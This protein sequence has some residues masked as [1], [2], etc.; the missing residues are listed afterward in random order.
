MT[1]FTPHEI[2]FALGRLIESWAQPLPTRIDDAP[3][4]ELASAIAGYLYLVGSING[5]IAR[6]E[7]STQGFHQRKFDEAIKAAKR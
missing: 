4:A 3:I 1:G 7:S 5:G 6:L 2:S